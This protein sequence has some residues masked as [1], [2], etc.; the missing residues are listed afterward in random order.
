MRQPR[1]S[2][3]AVVSLIARRLDELVDALGRDAVAGQVDAPLRAHAVA[4][5]ALAV[6]GVDHDPTPR[7]RVVWRGREAR[8]LDEHVE[9]V[10]AAPARR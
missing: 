4:E 9:Q 1:T 8:G 6:V 7:S 5:R 3:G 10:A 2:A